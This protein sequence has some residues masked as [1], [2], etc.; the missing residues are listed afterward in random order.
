MARTEIC[1]WAAVFLLAACGPREPAVQPQAAGPDAA[2]A[3]E[4]APGAAASEP[5]PESQSP[6]ASKAAHAP[7]EALSPVQQQCDKVCKVVASKC[8]KA[9]AE[10]CEL[11]CVNYEKMPKACEPHTL[12]ALRCYETAK[13]LPCASMAPETCRKEFRTLTDCQK[14]PDTFQVKVEEK[15]KLPDGWGIYDEGTFSVPAPGGVNKSSV[16]KE[17]VWTATSGKVRYVV[18]KLPVPS[19]K[20][21]PKSQ[22]RLANEWLK[23]C[24]LKL[25]LHGHVEKPDRSS[26]L[27]TSGCKDGGVR[28]GQIHVVANATY[29]VGI[30]APAGEKAE[31]ETFV[32]GFS[33]K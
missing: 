18:R 12:A 30:E 6:P 23:P 10:D 2:A 21:T 26:L 4:P 27:Y 19:E 20:L 31:M 24:T 29:I 15:K 9:V 13:D 5:Q 28:Q 22:L 25:K 7:E 16:D 3:S 11:M 14:A 17:T 1:S 33:L 8:S 32:Y